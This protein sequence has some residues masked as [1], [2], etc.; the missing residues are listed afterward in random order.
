MLIGLLFFCESIKSKNVQMEDAVR[1]PLSPVNERKFLRL[2]YSL[3]FLQTWC[4]MFRF[5][6]LPAF[7]WG[8]FSTRFHQSFNQECFKNIHI[9]LLC[10]FS[11]SLFLPV[12]FQDHQA[13]RQRFSGLWRSRKYNRSARSSIVLQEE[14]VRKF[15]GEDKATRPLPSHTH[16]SCTHLLMEALITKF[17]PVN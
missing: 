9:K 3:D 2:H 1:P 14:K 6:G 5:M 8:I 15:F 11:V 4:Q 17:L 7:N 16:F 13:G 10:F 12:I